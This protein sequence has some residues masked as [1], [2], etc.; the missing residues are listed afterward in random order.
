MPNDPNKWSDINPVAIG[1]VMAVLVSL[2][3]LLYDNNERKPIRIAL[4]AILCGFLS[5][6][7]SSGVLALHIDANWAIFSGG[8]IGYLGPTAV[9]AIALKLVE[10]RIK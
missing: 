1:A 4:E 2:L 8:A 10:K 9:R 5:L 6:T 7:V 3:R